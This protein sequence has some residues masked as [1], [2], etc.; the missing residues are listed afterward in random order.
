MKE[1]HT[2]TNTINEQQQTTRE[3]LNMFLTR[4]C[5]PLARNGTRRVLNIFLQ[6]AVNVERIYEQQ[7]G[8]KFWISLRV[9]LDNEFW[10]WSSSAL[11]IESF[12]AA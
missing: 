8:I 9:F 6:H 12:A 4:M 3:A 5:E 1:L 2:A 7:F 11:S 10:K